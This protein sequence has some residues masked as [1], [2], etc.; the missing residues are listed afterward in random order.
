MCTHFKNR[1]CRPFFKNGMKLPHVK[2]STENVES[3]ERRGYNIFLYKSTTS[4]QKLSLLCY[5]T[6][7]TCYANNI[8]TLFPIH[9]KKKAKKEDTTIKSFQIENGTSDGG[10]AKIYATTKTKTPAK[11]TDCL[12][13]SLQFDYPVAYCHNTLCHCR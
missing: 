13:T 10:N 7:F 1:T 12:T 11:L 8:I 9:C 3:F 5:N 6:T 4:S 2:F